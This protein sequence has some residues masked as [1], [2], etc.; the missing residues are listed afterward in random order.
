MQFQTHPEIP[1]PSFTI[2]N[3]FELSLQISS[4]RKRS[5]A[6]SANSN[7]E[8]DRKTRAPS[9]TKK[10]KTTKTLLQRTRVLAQPRLKTVQSWRKTRNRSPHSLW[11][12]QFSVPWLLP[13]QVSFSSKRSI[14]FS[15]SLTRRNS[16]AK[17]KRTYSRGFVMNSILSY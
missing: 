13:L 12:E 17:S 8:L 15:Q 7:I 1:P 16:L 11:S 4:N 5:T 6:K 3:P 9:K 14:C 10:R 2:K